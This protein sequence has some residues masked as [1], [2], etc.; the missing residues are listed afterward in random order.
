MEWRIIFI[1]TA[2]VYFVT[3]I[4]FV[5]FASGEVQP[6]NDY[7]DVDNTTNSEKPDILPPTIT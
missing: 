1:I 3:D 6:W 2:C 5:I 7:M 4:V